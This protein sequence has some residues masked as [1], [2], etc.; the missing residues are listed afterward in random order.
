M[1]A[2]FAD[3]NRPLYP[4]CACVHACVHACVFGCVSVPPSPLLP[5]LSSHSFLSL[6]FPSPPF[7]FLL[8]AVAARSGSSACASS[9]SKRR[10]ARGPLF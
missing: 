2:P 7:S 1:S 10:A 3:L 9:G 4:L 8:F 5:S 6:L